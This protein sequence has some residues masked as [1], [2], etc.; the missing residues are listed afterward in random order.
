[1]PKDQD[2][3]K[4]KAVKWFALSRARPDTWHIFLDDD[5]YPLDTKFLRDIAYYDARRYAVGNG[6][7]LPRLGR[8]ALAYALD[9]IRRFDDLTRLRLALEVLRRSISGMHGELSIIQG[10]VLREVWPAM[11]DTVTEDF[12]LAMKLVKRRYRTFQSRTYVSIKSPNSLRDF[13]RQR[14]R[15]ASD[16]GDAVMYR[17]PAPPP[18][19]ALATFF[20]AAIPSQPYIAP[21]QP[22]QSPRPTPPCISAA[23]S[24]PNAT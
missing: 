4:Y 19:T 5:S 13:V 15:C 24:K 7:L 22:R 17:N 1:V 21:P 20:S 16:L 23:A 14:A 12:K 10:D 3:T 11:G 18:S 2:R 6:V 8:S 9:W